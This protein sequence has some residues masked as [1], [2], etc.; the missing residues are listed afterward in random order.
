MARPG[1]FSHRKF[2]KLSRLLK[3]E[4]LAVGHLEIMWHHAYE[5]GD[6]RLGDGPEVE[7]AA[8]WRGKPGLLLAALVESGFIDRLDGDS[9]A[10]HDLFDHAPAYV[11][12]RRAREAQR[13]VSD[14]SVTSQRPVT[15]SPL[16]T[17]PAPS[18]RSQHPKTRTPKPPSAAPPG[19]VEFWDAYPARNGAKQGKAKALDVWKR[20]G[21]EARTD[22]IVEVLLAECG[23]RRAAQAR[24]DFFAAPCDAFRWLRDRRY[25]DRSEG[26][27]EPN[28]RYDEEEN[29]PLTDEE[30]AELQARWGKMP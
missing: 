4:A 14:Q 19:F 2:R 29:R 3:S 1:L 21:L 12:K 22:E 25:E 27:E 28:G 23:A 8:H 11:K 9:Y 10:V 18:T 6:A 30:A 13:K 15:D 16:T 7:S 24:G 20:D 17:T 26:P 5:D